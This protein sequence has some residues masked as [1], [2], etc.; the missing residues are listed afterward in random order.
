ME[1]RAATGREGMGS[2][3]AIN[4]P[5][6]CWPARDTHHGMAMAAGEECWRRCCT[7]TREG[8]EADDVV[9]ADEARGRGRASLAAGAAVPLP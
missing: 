6:R 2:P 5:F 9:V 1:Q 4:P 8:G 3:V 7:A